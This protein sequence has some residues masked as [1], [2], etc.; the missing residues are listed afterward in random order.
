MVMDSLAMQACI[1]TDAADQSQDCLFGPAISLLEYFFGHRLFKCL[2]PLPLAPSRDIAQ[3][4]FQK[5][6]A[7]SEA[8]HY[9]LE[10]RIC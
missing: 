3:K 5:H 8:T 10:L 1:A 2:H 9:P 6:M 4:T 7:I